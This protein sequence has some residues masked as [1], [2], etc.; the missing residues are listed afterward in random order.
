MATEQV[1]QWKQ[2][3]QRLEVLQSCLIGSTFTDV[4]LSGASFDDVNLSGATIRNA[5]LSGWKIEDVTLANLRVTNADLRGVSIADCLTE[6]MTID[7]IAVADMMAA[8]RNAQSKTDP[9][10]TFS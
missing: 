7:G 5:N 10:G 8:Y 9:S 3:D 6:G 4:N 1:V 2:V